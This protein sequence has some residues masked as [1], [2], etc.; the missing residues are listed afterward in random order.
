MKTLTWLLTLFFCVNLSE[1]NRV[2][3][4]VLDPDNFVFVEAG[5]VEQ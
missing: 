4:E 1:V 2:I 5:A 3:R